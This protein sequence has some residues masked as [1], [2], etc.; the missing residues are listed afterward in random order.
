MRQPPLSR[1]C[2]GQRRPFHHIPALDPWMRAAAC[3]YQVIVAEA[4]PTYE[5]QRMACELAALGI[6]TTAITDSVIYAMMARVNKVGPVF[7]EVCSHAIGHARSQDIKGSPSPNATQV[8]V[9]A[10]A[11]LAD[12]GIMA[13]IGMHLVA[14]AAKDHAVPVVVLCGIYKLT[15]LFA[16][17][18]GLNFNELKSP[19]SIL[20]YSDEALLAA[21]RNGNS[22]L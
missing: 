12:G 15:P 8:V 16:H 19:T 13:P 5:G 14:M 3:H 20:P 6:Q 17:E 22:R 11:L 7:C 18:P 21:G 2:M 4:A 10:H 1:A 9:T